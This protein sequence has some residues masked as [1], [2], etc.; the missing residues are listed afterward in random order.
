MLSKYDV[1]SDK[2]EKFS[3]IV[4]SF[5]GAYALAFTKKKKYEVLKKYYN[6]LIKEAHILFE[7]K[8]DNLD[9]I[10]DKDISFSGNKI[11]VSKIQKTSSELEKIL[12]I[13]AILID[14]YENLVYEFIMDLIAKK[15][16]E[17]EAYD[18][19]YKHLNKEEISVSETINTSNFILDNL[20]DKYKNAVL[21]KHKDYMNKEINKYV[22]KKESSE[23]EFLKGIKIYEE[24]V[25]LNI[26]VPVN[27]ATK[28]LK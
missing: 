4:T 17:D 24:N 5:I 28:K 23:I 6:I 22:N 16:S 11:F 13:D 26:S 1:M 18:F 27:N 10:K 7:I 14:K 15:K 20:D 8:N 12:V 25:N 2:M 21:K 9:Y 3:S 19:I